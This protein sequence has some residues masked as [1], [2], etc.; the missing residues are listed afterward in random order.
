MD[1]SNNNW[2]L[3]SW[4]IS[5]GVS[6]EPLLLLASMSFDIFDKCRH[7][8]CKM[9]TDC[10]TL[11]SSPRRL[12]IIETLND[13]YWPRTLMTFSFS[14]ISGRGSH[15]QVSTYP[16]DVIRL[17]VIAVKLFVGASLWCIVGCAFLGSSSLLSTLIMCATGHLTAQA[18]RIEIQAFCFRGI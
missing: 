11:L 17:L 13:G 18:L 7:G 16:C 15:N 9:G 1:P 8:L 12:P 4:V 3:G 14:F 2:R 6:P 5:L 10:P